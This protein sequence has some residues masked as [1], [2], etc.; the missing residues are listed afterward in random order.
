MA[1]FA[2]I[3]SVMSEIELLKLLK[4]PNI[5]KYIETVRTADTLNI[6]TEFVENGS[7]QSLVKK[8]GKL[9]ESLV[10]MIIMNVCD[11]FIFVFSFY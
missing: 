1:N 4:H 7:L 8:F 3:E 10:H 11:F 2:E 6:V 5:V 9:M